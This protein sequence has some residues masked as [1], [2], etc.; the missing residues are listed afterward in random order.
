MKLTNPRIEFMELPD[1]PA[2][3]AELLDALDRVKV[4]CDVVERY[5]GPRTIA[6]RI[7]PAPGTTIAR[8]KSRM[9]DLAI[10]LEVPEC[11][12]REEG[13]MLFLEVTKN[14]PDFPAYDALPLPADPRDILV[15]V[16]TTGNPVTMRLSNMPHCIVAGTSGSGKSVALRSII[17]GV[18]RQAG[19]S[20]YVVDPK[21]G[22]DF[23]DSRTCRIERSYLSVECGRRR[24]TSMR[25]ADAW[26]LLNLRRGIRRQGY[27]PDT[28]PME[29]APLLLVVDELQS[30]ID[31]SKNHFALNQLLAMGRSYNI[32]CVLATQAPSAKLLGGNEIRLNAPTR[33]VLKVTTSSDSRVALTQSGAEK[34][35][36]RGDALFLYDGRITRMQVPYLEGV[37]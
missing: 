17:R 2:D 25:I 32:H 7:M 14:S 24:P 15:G 6:Y 28:A 31:D 21:N 9:S 12:C 3:Q 1:L 27:M 26:G 23:G 19:S 35:L 5:E 16:D 33:L 13:G 10:Q 22:G 29:G 34:L 36:G 18:L 20:V 37:V 4:S 11:V 8:V 30:I